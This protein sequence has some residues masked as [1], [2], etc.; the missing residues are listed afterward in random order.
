MIPKVFELFTR[1]D[2]ARAGGMGGL[3]I[4]LAL[5]QRLVELHG[6]SVEAHS[7]GVG[8]GAE[9]II[10]LPSIASPEGVP[11][12]DAETA[13]RLVAGRPRILVVDDHR[14]G[15]DSLAVLLRNHG[16]EVHVAYDGE[17][18]VTLADRI[19][20]SIVILDIGLP[21]ISGEEVARRI[22]QR[23]WAARATVIAVSGWGK[24]KDRE[25]AQDA[26]VNAH[27]VK[28]VD[29]QELLRLISSACNEPG[30]SL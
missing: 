25:R 13:E 22:R 6:G 19:E 15:A 20:P 14:D 3:G 11:G 16:L 2:R 23:S 28:P 7:E 10:R 26:G 5:V 29:P 30:D 27:L 24:D 18:A 8:L 17:S 12:N 1:A 9:F 4:G 21:D